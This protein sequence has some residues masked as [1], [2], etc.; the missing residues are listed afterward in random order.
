[1]RNDRAWQLIAISLA[2]AWEIIL[3]ADFYQALT[4]EERKKVRQYWEAYPN[5]FTELYKALDPDFRD[6]I[7]NVLCERWKP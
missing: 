1:M 3:E 2:D 6:T 7:F 5:T 4:E